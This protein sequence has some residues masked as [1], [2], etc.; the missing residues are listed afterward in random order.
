M[1][2]KISS[3]TEG[4]Q[5]L[6]HPYSVNDITQAFKLDFV[7]SSFKKT[8]NSCLRKVILREAVLKT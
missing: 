3:K 7:L 2:K 4:F 6:T 8:R 5:N 1:G